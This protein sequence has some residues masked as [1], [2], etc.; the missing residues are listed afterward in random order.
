MK[1]VSAWMISGVFIGDIAIVHFLTERN[2]I[3]DSTDL[4][5]LSVSVNFRRSAFRLVQ[6]QGRRRYGSRMPA[7]M[8]ACCKRPE[9]FRFC[10]IDE[11]IQYQCISQDISLRINRCVQTL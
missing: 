2:Q 10:A 4:E 9:S 11:C 5:T 1:G 8:R 7:S 6:A 3:S